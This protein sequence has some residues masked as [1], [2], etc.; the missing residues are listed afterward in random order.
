MYQRSQPLLHVLLLYCC[1]W[2]VVGPVDWLRVC[3]TVC[4]YT[5]ASH[6]FGLLV[7]H[8]TMQQ[9]TPLCF[10]LVRCCFCCAAVL[11]Y[12][13]SRWVVGWW[14]VI[15]SLLL[16]FA[17]AT[18]GFGF[19]VL[20]NRRRKVCCGTRFLMPRTVFR[21]MVR[22]F[23]RLMVPEA[24]HVFEAPSYVLRTRKNVFIASKRTP[25]SVFRAYSHAYIAL[26][27]PRQPGRPP[28]DLRASCG[29]LTRLRSVL[30]ATCLTLV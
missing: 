21:L 14:K 12:M 29:G 3:V 26:L 13:A 1:T 19:A 27:G 23:F 20:R 11:L 22:V 16:Y 24:I 7:R 18:F 4:W 10:V 9:N 17:G 5:L 28:A 6:V 30:R 25:S 8:R 15:N 2:W